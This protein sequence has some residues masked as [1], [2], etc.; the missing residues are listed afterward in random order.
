MIYNPIC[1]IRAIETGSLYRAP[2]CVIIVPLE[3]KLDMLWSFIKTHL[4]A[5]ILVFLSSC[6]QVRVNNFFYSI[7]VH[8]CHFVSF[9]VFL[10]EIESEGVTFPSINGTMMRLL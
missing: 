8:F 7:V 9:R 2:I 4:N 3:Q 1:E 5:K 10:F 6:K